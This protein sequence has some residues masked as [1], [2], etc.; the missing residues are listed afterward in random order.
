GYRQLI[1]EFGYTQK[2]VAETVGRVRST[3]ANLLRLLHLP[4]PVQRLVSQ[5]A[6]T[7]GHARAL[8]G[9]GDERR[10]TELARR[11]ASEGLSVRAV[12]DLVRKGRSAS[13]RG[14]ARGGH[15]ST[16]P[17]VRDMEVELQRLL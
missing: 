5:G 12:E 9:A 14:R 4:S 3:I 11:V 6:L 10:M 1:E 2:D 7:M 8:L 17:Y 15:S 13:K 16:D